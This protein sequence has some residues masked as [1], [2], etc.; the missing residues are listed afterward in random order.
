MTGQAQDFWNVPGELVVAFYILGVI[1]VIV[2]FVGFWI[3][4]RRWSKGE[5]TNG[6]LKGLGPA[7]LIWLSITKFFSPDCLLAKR[8]FPR[9][10][11]RTIF[12]I[13]IVWGT[14]ILFL[15]TVGRSFNT[16]IYQFL[17]NRAW[18]TFSAV[19][20]IAGLYALIGIIYFLSRR[21]IR[22]PERI[23]SGFQ[24][25]IFL[26][27][28]FLILV[29]GFVIEGIRIVILNPPALDWSFV[30]YTFGM[31][32]YLAAGGNTAVL[33]ST[34]L[35]LKVIHGAFAIF[36]VAY[37]PFSKGLHLFAAQITTWLA[38]ERKRDWQTA[39]AGAAKAE[40]A[41]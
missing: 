7:R 31:I 27:L 13:G 34:Y 3:R 33:Q 10:R 36:F 5:D 30:G 22:K 17:S 41:K 8:V 26:L 16:H 6:S 25:S 15:G 40:L 39:V 24:D 11:V 20:D 28:L 2:F 1:A 35:T 32:T 29:T 14:V 37:I 19:L 12:L 21:Y 18:L 9:S 4:I 23:V 38:A